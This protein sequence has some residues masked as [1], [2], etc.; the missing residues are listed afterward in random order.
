VKIFSAHVAQIK[1]WLPNACGR[2]IDNNEIPA[3]AETLMRS[4][5]TAYTLLREDYLLANL[6][7]LPPDH[8]N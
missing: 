6:R 8:H 2:Y 7:R 1:K 4:R 3:T 5:Y